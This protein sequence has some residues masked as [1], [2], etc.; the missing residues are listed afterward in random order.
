MEA[1]GLSFGLLALTRT[2]ARVLTFAYVPF[3][4]VHDPGRDRGPYLRA[5]AEAL[6]PHL[7]RGTAFLRFDLPWEKTGDRPE[8]GGLRKSSDDIQPPSTVMVDLSPP[9]E[10][11][12]SSMKPKTRYNIRL[13]EKKGVTVSEGA[14]ADLDAWY[15]LYRETAER[16]KIAIHSKAYYADLFRAAREYGAAA[17]RVIL[18]LARAEGELLAGNIVILWKETGIYL[19]GASSGE[20][21]N[22]MPTYAL[23]WEA[24]R[25]A[26]ERGCL[27]YDL[28]GVPPRPDPGHPMFGLY[29]FKTGFTDKVL[30]R[31]GTWDAPYGKAAFAA[32][33]AAES[34]RLFFFR[35][36]KK[37]RIRKKRRGST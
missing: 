5:L 22:L 14:D 3:G 7:P 25:A 35:V 30:E 37:G 6:R 1:D 2:V 17:P 8:A 23:Q 31:W 13:A 27:R 32:Y 33:R 24:M 19:Y 34:A 21:R 16:D 36:I 9:L 26:R 10:G 29:Q 20:K 12:L 11:V 15:G 4:P 18:F 28:Y